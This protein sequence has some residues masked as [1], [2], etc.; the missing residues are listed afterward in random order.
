MEAM[1]NTNL[2]TTIISCYSATD[3]SDET[4][5]ITFDNELSSLSLICCIRKHK[6]LINSGDM[7]AQI[8]KDKNNKFSLHNSSNRNGRTSNKILTRK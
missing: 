1:F 4:D 2:S 8:G 7:N 3:V 6:V 5:F